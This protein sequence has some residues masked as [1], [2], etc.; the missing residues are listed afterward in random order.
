MDVPFL[1][2]EMLL[3]CIIC[4]MVTLHENHM[5]ENV[6]GTAHRRVARYASR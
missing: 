1:H 6:Y 4:G 2:Q 3:G 5:Q